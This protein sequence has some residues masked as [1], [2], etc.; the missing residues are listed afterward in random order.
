[1]EPSN[2]VDLTTR[3]KNIRLSLNSQVQEE[4][5]TNP[6]DFLSLIQQRKNHI[7]SQWPDFN[8]FSNWSDFSNWGK[9]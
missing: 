4:F 9:Y 7:E 2:S 5:S 8:D 6:N 3:V 1:M